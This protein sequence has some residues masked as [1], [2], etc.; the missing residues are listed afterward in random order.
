MGVHVE[1]YYRFRLKLW[2]GVQLRSRNPLS[3]LE[4]TCKVLCNIVANIFKK[5]AEQSL[6]I[7]DRSEN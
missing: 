2:H 4:K 1:T 6:G 5:N 3:V 7:P